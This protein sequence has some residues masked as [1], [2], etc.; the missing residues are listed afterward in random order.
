MN[1][2]YDAQFKQIKN[3]N[4][5]PWIGANYDTSK[6]L[7]VADSH[8]DDGCGW[9]DG[10]PLATKQFINNQGL[11]SDKPQFS[12]AKI[13]REI[14][15]AVMNVPNTSYEQRL[16]FWNGVSYFNLSPTLMPSPRVRPSDDDFDKGWLNFMEI[17]DIIKPKYIIKFAYAGIGPLGAYLAHPQ[18]TW[19]GK[20]V[21][22]FYKKPFVVNLSHKNAD[23]YKIVFTHHPTGARGYNYKKWAEQIHAEFPD[24]HTH[25]NSN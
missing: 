24:L 25:F 22:D 12:K 15:K 11:Q 10:N 23:Q 17:V 14:E 4:W 3:I 7:L 6:I 8:Y 9:L 13:L 21:K 18:E 1:S 16:S 5:Q 20:N 2:T 19:Q